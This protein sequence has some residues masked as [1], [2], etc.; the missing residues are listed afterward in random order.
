MDEEALAEAVWAYDP[1]GILGSRED[2]P[3]EYDELIQ[4]IIA[5]RRI[6]AETPQIEQW[7]HHFFTSVWGAEFTANAAREFV[8]AVLG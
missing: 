3:T 6:A 5:L 7:V 2:I 8:R 1:M 4:G